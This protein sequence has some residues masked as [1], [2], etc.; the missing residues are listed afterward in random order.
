M[1][2]AFI[3]IRV[4][5]LLALA[6]AALTGSSSTAAAQDAPVPPPPPPPVQAEGNKSA[7]SF[8]GFARLDV[9]I[10][11]SRINS[12]QTPTFVRSEP[13]GAENRSNFTMHP[14]LTRFGVNYKAPAISN[15]PAVVGKIEIDFHNGGSNS[16]AIPRYRHVYV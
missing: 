11:D 15:G 3:S 1:H 2:S 6:G 5:A 9:A 8:Y 14:R 10:D 7:V 13:T 4:F 12:F 16:R